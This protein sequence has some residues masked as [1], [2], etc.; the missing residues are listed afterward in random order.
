MATNSGP[1]ET[2]RPD[3]DQ[4]ASIPAMPRVA[5]GQL[6][7]GAPFMLLDDARHSIGWQDVRKAGPVFVVTTRRAVGTNK[8]LQ[9]FPLSEQGWADAW[10]LLTRLDAGAAAALEAKLAELRAGR[11]AA[12]ALTGLNAASLCY[13]GSVIFDAGS[14]AGLLTRGQRC[15]LRFQNDHIMVCT[16]RSTH[17]FVELPYADVETVEVSASASQPARV[18]LQWICW[19]GLLGA[20][21][22]FLLIV[23]RPAGL[24]I[25]AVVLGLVGG[26]IAA[27][28]SK[29]E[30]IVLV[31]GRDADFQFL[32]PFKRADDVRRALSEALM[33]I[34]RARVAADRP[35]EPAETT[36]N[37]VADQLSKLASL[38]RQGVISRDEFE[39]LKAKVIAKS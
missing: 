9:R 27:A 21:F 39:R 2:P 22:G 37:S 19:L 4:Q 13:L 11:R 1:Q 17:A 28:T 32:D 18:M 14:D 12:E 16:E 5:P 33:A 3:G 15:D 23:P 29:N 7:R 20:L 34:R 6:Y 35:D 31:R 24:L 25:G 30:T 8:V 38:L 26:L 10:Q 36:S